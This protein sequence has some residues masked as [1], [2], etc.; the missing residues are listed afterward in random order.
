VLAHRAKRGV[1]PGGAC[2]HHRDVSLEDWTGLSGPHR[3]GVGVKRGFEV[4]VVTLGV[5]RPEAPVLEVFGRGVVLAPV[6][7]APGFSPPGAVAVPGVVVRGRV[8]VP[9]SPVP[10][11]L[12]LGTVV[13]AVAVG[14]A[15]TVGAVVTAVVAGA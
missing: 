15:V 3:F 7:L 5:V 12:V 14:V 11:V 6:R 4:G 8:L 9:V 13:G 1:E 10:G 2:A